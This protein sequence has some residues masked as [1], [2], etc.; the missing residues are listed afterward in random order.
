MRW[1]EGR[2]ESERDGRR[3]EGK[4]RVDGRW[5]WRNL[6]PEQRERDTAVGGEA[7]KASFSLS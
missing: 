7:R 2:S 6:E 1:A 3:E 4:M 5:R